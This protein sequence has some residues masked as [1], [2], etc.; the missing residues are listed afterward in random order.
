MYEWF[1]RAGYSV[2]IAGLR[3]EHP[4]VGWQQYHRWVAGQGLE[5]QIKAAS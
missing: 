1:E 4:E 5:N 2:D 3:R